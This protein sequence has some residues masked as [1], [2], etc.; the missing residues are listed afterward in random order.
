MPV[1]PVMET[2]RHLDL[3]ITGRRS[4]HETETWVHP[5]ALDQLESRVVLSRTTQGLATVVSGL[6][7]RL[8]VLNREQQAMSAEIQQAFTSF[9]NDYDQARATYFASISNQPSPSPATTNAF[10]LYTTERVSLLAQQLINI[11]IQ[12]PQGTAKAPGQ[13]YAVKQLITTKIIGNQGEHPRGSLDQSLMN[14]IPQ[15]GTSAPTASLYTLSQDEA[16]QTA[17]VAILNGLSIIKN[18]AFG[19]EKVSHY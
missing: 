19:V 18:G 13:P 5:R 15:P 9:D 6:S 12:S 16:I 14:T 7:P 3:W 11:F 17:E 4:R 10:T 1:T 2:R 8:R